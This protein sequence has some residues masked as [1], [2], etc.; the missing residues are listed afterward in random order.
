MVITSAKT[1]MENQEWKKHPLLSL[2][3]SAASP[4]AEKVHDGDNQMPFWAGH[5]FP[6]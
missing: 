2:G 6:G 4:A 5:I 3:F 1:P